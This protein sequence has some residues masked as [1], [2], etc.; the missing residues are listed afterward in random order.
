MN[1]TAEYQSILRSASDV[2]ALKVRARDAVRT[3]DDAAHALHETQGRLRVWANVQAMTPFGAVG[4][5]IV[6]VIIGLLMSS[7]LPAGAVHFGAF[8][9]WS[10]LGLGGGGGLLFWLASAVVGDLRQQA[11]HARSAVNLADIDLRHAEADLASAA[12]GYWAKKRPSA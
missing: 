1:A 9:V 8:T 3:A 7:V 10:V 6:A 4:A 12:D 11:M 5:V 2:A